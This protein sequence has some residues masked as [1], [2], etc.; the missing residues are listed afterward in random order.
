M[1]TEIKDITPE[2]AAVWL[3]RNGVKPETF[4]EIAN[5]KYEREHDGD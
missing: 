3:S 5:V 4:P 1:R 2:I